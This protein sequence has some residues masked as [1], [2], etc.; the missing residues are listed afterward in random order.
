MNRLGGKRIIPITEIRG[1]SF[2]LFEMMKPVRNKNKD[3]RFVCPKKRK[4]TDTVACPHMNGIIHKMLFVYNLNLFVQ[5]VNLRLKL[6]H[7]LFHLAHT[8]LALGQLL[9]DAFRLLE[10]LYRILC[11]LYSACR[12]GCRTFCCSLKLSTVAAFWEKPVMA[13][14]DIIPINS[15]FF[16]LKN[17]L[18]SHC[19]NTYF[20]YHTSN[21]PHIF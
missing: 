21:I 10:F 1:F 16:I 7:L 15:N 13:D 4:R 8:L 12:I 20:F 9:V 5:F 2:S 17:I 14:K 18:N 3:R 6:G 19:K 11:L